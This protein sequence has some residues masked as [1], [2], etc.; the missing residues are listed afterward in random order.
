MTGG[1]W[2]METRGVRDVMVPTGMSFDANV[3]SDEWTPPLTFQIEPERRVKL[4]Q[5][6]SYG[7]LMGP[8]GGEAIAVK[9]TVDGDNVRIE[10]DDR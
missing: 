6:V 3:P 1:R 5:G 7:H 10:A 4:V 2:R 8:E 9:V